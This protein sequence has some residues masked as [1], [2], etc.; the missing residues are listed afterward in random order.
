MK[1]VTRNIRVQNE[2]LT[3]TFVLCRARQ[4]VAYVSAYTTHLTNTS[5]TEEVES[6]LQDTEKE[7]NYEELVILRRVAMQRVERERA[8]AEVSVA[9]VVLLYVYSIYPSFHLHPPIYSFLLPPI[10]S[11]LHPPIYSFLHASM[12]PFINSCLYIHT[13]SIHE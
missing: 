7:L 1:C 10:Y 13:S 11:F 9:L 4:C 6:V 5:V 12:Y 3:L 2:R 8:L